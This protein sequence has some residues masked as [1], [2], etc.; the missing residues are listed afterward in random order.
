MKMEV[1]GVGVWGKSPGPAVHFD[2]NTYPSSSFHVRAAHFYTGVVGRF[3]P[4]NVSKLNGEFRTKMSNEH[5]IYS[6]GPEAYMQ[7]T[8]PNQCMSDSDGSNLVVLG[9]I[10]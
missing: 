2:L 6:T 5:K 1:V 7:S 8:A 10:W 9:P 3:L 4:G